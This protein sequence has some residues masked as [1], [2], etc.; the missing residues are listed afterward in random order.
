MIFFDVIT[1][2]G[3]CRFNTFPGE[4]QIPIP[5]HPK[6]NLL[7]DT[8]MKSKIEKEARKE[9]KKEEM[10]F[11]LCSSLVPCFLSK[12]DEA[13]W[14]WT[15]FLLLKHCSS[16]LLAVILTM[17]DPCRFRPFSSS[18]RFRPQP[19]ESLRSCRIL[20]SQALQIYLAEAPPCRHIQDGPGYR[21]PPST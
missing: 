5:N 9:G 8:V 20:P 14:N 1:A 2:F 16:F 21:A 3:L 11:E 7:H 15:A 13:I 17:Y 6:S 12:Y 19:Y 18:A 4:V 10:L